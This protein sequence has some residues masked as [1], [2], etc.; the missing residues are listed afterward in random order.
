MV[1]GVLFTR[2]SLAIS[3]VILDGFDRGLMHLEAE[4]LGFPMSAYLLLGVKY[5]GK[6]S[7]WNVNWSWEGFVVSL[8]VLW[9]FLRECWRVWSGFVIWVDCGLG[10]ESNGFEIVEIGWEM[11]GQC[12]VRRRPNLHTSNVG[13]IV[14]DHIDMNFVY[15]NWFFNPNFLEFTCVSSNVS[16]CE[17]S[18]MCNWFICYIWFGISSAAALS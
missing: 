8:I 12:W 2:L 10:D 13:V 17:V 4:E 3:W 16:T 14:C 1:L 5:V 6:F 7:M 18:L 15:D 9:G 11:D